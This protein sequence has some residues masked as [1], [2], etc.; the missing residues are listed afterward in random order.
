[1]TF[2]FSSQSTQKLQGVHPDLVRVMNRALQLS[3]YDFRITHGVRT[4]AEQD[5]LYAQGRTKPGKIV[6]NTRSSRHIG[7]FAVDIAVLINGQVTWE[8]KHYAEVAVAV[9]KAAQELNIPIIWGGNWKTPVDGP[10][11]ELDKNFYRG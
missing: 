1:M 11:F 10:H 8:L 4:Q 5:A 2:K 9:K 6:T 7:G 3:P